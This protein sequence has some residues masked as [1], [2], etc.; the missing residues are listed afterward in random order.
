MF[1][2]H[3]TVFWIAGLS[4]TH[5]LTTVFF[6]AMLYVHLVTRAYGTP[7]YAWCTLSVRRMAVD[8]DR[9]V[10]PGSIQRS[11]DLYPP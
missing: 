1:T 10:N 3:N 2:T 6:F 11:P 9:P 8:R 5:A 4:C 7:L